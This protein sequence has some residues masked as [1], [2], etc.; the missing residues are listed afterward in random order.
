MAEKA[1]LNQFLSHFG[2]DPSESFFESLFRVNRGFKD[3]LTGSA[4]DP[5]FFPAKRMENRETSKDIAKDP[6]VLKTLRDSEFLRC[7]VFATPP[8]FP[9]HKLLRDSKSLCGSKLTT[10][11]NFTMA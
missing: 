7:S 11:S 6:A 10:P 9:R 1:L 5:F 2:A 8:R 3:T 4:R